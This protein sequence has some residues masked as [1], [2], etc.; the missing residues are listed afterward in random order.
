MLGIGDLHPLLNGGGKFARELRRTFLHDAEA[1]FAKAADDRDFGCATYFRAPTFLSCEF[2]VVAAINIL[3]LPPSSPLVVQT[4][5]LGASSSVISTTTLKRALIGPS[6]TP[7][8]LRYCLSE[9]GST[10]S[11][12]G[13]QGATV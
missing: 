11:Q 9:I 6:A 13:M 7:I 10:A 3:A 1:E 4:R 12:P 2:D 8:V 5:R